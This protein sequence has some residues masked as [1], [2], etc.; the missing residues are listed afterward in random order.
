MKEVLLQKTSPI[1]I[2]IADDHPVVR[3]GLVA[4]INRRPDMEVVAEASNGREAVAEFLLHRPDVA[5][6]DLRMPELDGADAMV[7]IREKA[8]AARVIVLTTYDDDEDIQRALRAGAKAYLLKDA[9]RDELLACIH[10]VHEGRTLIPPAIAAKLADLVGASTLTTRELEVLALVAD[11]NSNKVV[12][13]TLSIAEGTVK[14][15]VNA[16]LRKLD[17]ADRTQ[18]VT[19][20]LKRG[21]LRL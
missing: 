20:A 11:G 9:P 6:M 14:S 2:L 12:A 21:M 3:E 13:R 4:L 15:H 7:A 18:A 1:K 5:L 16:V 10:A 8:P 19:I 17:A